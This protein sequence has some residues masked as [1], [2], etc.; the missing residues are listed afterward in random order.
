MQSSIYL[1]VFSNQ[2]I[3]CKILRL[4]TVGRLSPFP[5]ISL[6]VNCYIRTL[7]GLLKKDRTIFL[8]NL[9]GSL[10]AVFCISSFHRFAGAKP[11]GLYALTVVLMGTAST[12]FLLD[13]A[14]SI[15]SMGC[16]LSVVLSGAPLAVVWTV[17]KERSTTAM[18]FSTSLLTWLNNLAW[19][20][21]GAFVAH[22]PLIYGPAILGGLLSSCQM[23][24]FLLFGPGE[25]P[26]PSIGTSHP[27]EDCLA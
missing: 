23:V 26:K 27:V 12:L 19:L 6:L 24:L 2:R 5:F 9:S 1:L 13:Q 20:A 18:P 14:A 8:P 15:G 17:V 3:A 10:V 16:F 7:Y 22:D 25:K 21:Y 11:Q 4:K